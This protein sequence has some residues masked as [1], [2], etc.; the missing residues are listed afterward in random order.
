MTTQPDN[1]DEILLV[2]FLLG[3]C[4]E[5]TAQTVRQ[6]LASDDAFRRRHADMG[7]A[8]S[9]LGRLPEAPPAPDLV[10]RTMA[11]IRSAR[12]LDAL[13]AR[14]ETSRR[15][16]RPTFS[17]REVAAVAAT[18]LILAS[19]FIPSIRQARHQAN[20]AA[21]A[22]QAG[23]IG[24]GLLTYAGNND[25]FL[26]DAS[27]TTRRWMA[28]GDQPAVS[29]SSALFKLVKGGYL[30]SPV[31]FQCPAVGGESFVVQANM[32]DF[33]APKYVSYSYQHTL[34]GDRVSLNDPQQSARADKL[35]VLADSTSLFDGGTYHPER[36][37]NLNS[38]NHGN[39]GQ[40]VLY[41]DMHVE[42]AKTPNAGV[43]G[44]N[45]YLA[46]NLT[47]YTGDEMPA[48]R[49][50]SFLLPSYTPAK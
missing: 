10:A 11:S 41:L 50:D 43:D 27:Q 19:V 20:E 48:S 38:L 46:G 31:A 34:G 44:D 45:I 6:R 2:D 15:V 4:D 26:P 28:G 5:A 18:L 35:A 47:N 32:L 9:A 29:N 14:Q 12:G 36:M 21:C 42:H 49:T 7:N 37:G 30:P 25:G 40:N 39:D 1:H 22:S 17:M 23:Q 3:R 16:L 24:T 8:F 13:I 33:P